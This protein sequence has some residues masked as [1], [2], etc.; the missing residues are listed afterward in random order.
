MSGKHVLGERSRGFQNRR[1]PAP[2]AAPEPTRPSPLG[3]GAQPTTVLQPMGAAHFADF[4]RQSCAAFAQDNV[5]AGRWP[6]A[7]ALQR[8]QRDFDQ[9]LP[10]GLQT[11]QHLFFEI[12]DGSQGLK[13]GSLWLALNDAGG[14]RVGYVYNIR[15][16]PEF[17]GRGHARAALQLAEAIAVARG[18]HAIALHV[19]IFNTSAQ[20]L[21][22]SLGYGITGLNMGKP[23]QRDPD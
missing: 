1:V 18:A 9:L 22:R 16:Q 21:Y 3:A 5:Q 8:A 20:A 15:V 19:F 2:D 6:E 10:Q 14:H 11:P 23:L 17:R 7:G 13:V 12:E 4:A